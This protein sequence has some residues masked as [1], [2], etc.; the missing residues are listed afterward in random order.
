VGLVIEVEAVADELFDF[1]FGGTVEAA[2]VGWAAALA[3][4]AIAAGTSAG[5][6]VRTA[7]SAWTISGTLSSWTRASSG[8][9]FSGRAVFSVALRCWL[10]GHIRL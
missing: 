1:D 10:I 7:V 9:V 2:V 8:A 5:A 6:L 4:L 3:S